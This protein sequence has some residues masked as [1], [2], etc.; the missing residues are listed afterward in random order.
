[1][2]SSSQMGEYEGHIERVTPAM[3]DQISGKLRMCLII[4]LRSKAYLF[5]FKLLGL[6]RDWIGLKRSMFCQR[7][8]IIK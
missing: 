8:K 7:G 5:S 1:M 3:N 6:K 4:S 2:C